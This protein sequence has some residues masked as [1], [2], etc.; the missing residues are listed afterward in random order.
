[1]S[2]RK[3]LILLLTSVVAVLGTD[4]RDT[5]DIKFQDSCMYRFVMNSPQIPPRANICTWSEI[6]C[7]DGSIIQVRVDGSSWF[8]KLNLCWLPSTVTKCHIQDRFISGTLETRY[9]PYKM[10]SFTV[11]KSRLPDTLALDTLPDVL[12]YFTVSYNNITGTISLLSLPMKIHYINL[13]GNKISQ[14]NV[15][16]SKLPQ[17][18]QSVV[19]KR[20]GTSKGESVCIRWIDGKADA[21]FQI[22][23]IKV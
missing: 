22:D 7:H 21:Q 4:W 6:V 18:L 11:S 12:H 2:A 3:I 8:S 15:A 13:A 16:Q 23:M 19:L 10:H 20:N 5:H 14:V 1:M 9:I 17:S